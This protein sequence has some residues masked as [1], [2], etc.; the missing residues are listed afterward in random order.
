MGQR[1]LQGLNVSVIGMTITISSLIALMLIIMLLSRLILLLQKKPPAV[2]TLGSGGN[3]AVAVDAKLDKGQIAE[4]ESSSSL[5]D[6]RT[7]G[8][9]VAIFAAVIAYST[10]AAPSSF[11]VVSYKKAGAAAPIWN[12][13]ARNDYLSGKL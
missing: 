10:G 1:I 7:N 5:S 11:R 9:L 2:N 3:L 13:R 12:A 4:S 8:E 6:K